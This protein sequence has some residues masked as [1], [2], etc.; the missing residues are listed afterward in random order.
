[1]HVIA[2][3]AKSCHESNEDTDEGIDFG[4][5][6]ASNQLAFNPSTLLMHSTNSHFRFY[7]MERNEAKKRID[8]ECREGYPYTLKFVSQATDPKQPIEQEYADLPVIYCRIVEKL[9][10]IPSHH[11][12]AQKLKLLGRDFKIPDCYFSGS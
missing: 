3:E 12:T 11:N 1:M 10:Q 9:Q 6:V 4:T 2:G 7:C 8:V 5:F